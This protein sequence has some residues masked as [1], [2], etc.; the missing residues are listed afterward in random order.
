MKYCCEYFPRIA[1]A[2]LWHSYTDEYGKENFLIP[3]LRDE[4]NQKI[5]VNNCPVCG[6]EVRGI[7]IHEDEFNRLK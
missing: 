7:T 6:A 4:Y 1:R 5:R 3:C 2:F